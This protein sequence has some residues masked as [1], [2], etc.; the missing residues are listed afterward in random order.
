MSK[1]RLLITDSSPEFCQSTTA[2]LQDFAEIQSCCHG[3]QALAQLRAQRYDLMLLELSLPELDGLTLLRTAHAEGILPATLV[4]LDLQSPY[5]NKALGSLQISYAMRKPCAPDAIAA[6]LRSM[7]AVCCDIPSLPAPADDDAV[8]AL[9][10]KLLLNPNHDGFAYLSTAIPLYAANPS[11]FI[12][13]ELYSAVGKPFG[14]S[15]SQVERSMRTAI[16]R[17]WEADQAGIWQ[18]YFPGMTARPSNRVFIS[19]MARLLFP[20]D[21]EKA[22]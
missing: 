18:K 16:E 17:A 15:V 14:K 19:A 8:A 13:K 21:R 9:Q 20:A 22:I 7:A 6:N 4:M 5:I 12:T 10:R 1:P 3:R 11:Q 2:L